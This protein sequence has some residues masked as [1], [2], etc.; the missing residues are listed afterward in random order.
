[1]GEKARL[2]NVNSMNQ[3][4]MLR[5]C[6]NIH[7][8]LITNLFLQCNG[9]NTLL[10]RKLPVISEKKGKSKNKILLMYIISY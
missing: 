6:A 5:F 7:S 3:Q 10:L 4:T 9:K 1:M 2:A 8:L